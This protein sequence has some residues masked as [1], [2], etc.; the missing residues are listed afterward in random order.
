MSGREVMG[1]STQ[2]RQ[3]EACKRYMYVEPLAGREQL[4]SSWRPLPL[5]GLSSFFFFDAF[6]NSE[7][8]LIPR[9]PWEGK[10]DRGWRS[11]RR[12]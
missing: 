7:P 11:L 2:A 8:H 3:G 10:K 5:S 9:P 6:W 12:L 4:V 1:Q